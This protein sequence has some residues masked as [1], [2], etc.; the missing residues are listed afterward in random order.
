MRRRTDEEDQRRR[1]KDQLIVPWS[2]VGLQLSVTHPRHH[3]LLHHPAHSRRLADHIHYLAPRRHVMRE[4][5]RV[6]LD[7]Q[8]RADLEAPQPLLVAPVELL[9]VGGRDRPL[10]RPRAPVDPAQQRRHAG[11]QVDQ[12]RRRGDALGQR[13]EQP[14]VGAKIAMREDALL[15]QALDEH[16]VILVDAA[17]LADRD[18]RVGD[19]QVLLVALRQK[20]DLRMKAPALLVGVVVV[21]VGVIGHQLVVGLPAELFGQNAHQRALADADIAGDTDV[22]AAG[23]ACLLHWAILLIAA[24]PRRYD[25]ISFR[26]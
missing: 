10:V 25:S 23:R 2:F 20:P 12:Q 1:T 3:P 11:V 7:R 26:L 24:W 18:R 14:P 6:G 5:Q 8:H 22:L 15:Q 4:I 13:V 16:L 19:L 21:Q 9:K 17:I